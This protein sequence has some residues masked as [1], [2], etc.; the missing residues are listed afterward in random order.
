MQIRALKQKLSKT[1]TREKRRSLSLKGREAFTISK[2][3]EEKLTELE[4]KIT[5]LDCS[6]VCTVST[7][8]RRIVS[9]P[10]P[11]PDLS[12]TDNVS[13]RLRRKSLDSA[14]SSEPMKVLLRLRSL[15]S[16]VA[17]LSKDNIICSHSP[18]CEHSSASSFLSN[19][20]MNIS[21]DSSVQ[22]NPVELKLFGCFQDETDYNIDQQKLSVLSE[23]KKMENLLRS[24]LLE[25]AKKRESLIS[26]GQWNNE[27]RVSLLAEKL[28]Y[29]SVLIGRL[30]D[31]VSGSSQTDI[32]DSERLMSELDDKLSGNKPNIETSLDYL[33][34]TLSRH[35]LEQS[36][37]HI[38][39]RK[40]KERRRAVETQEIKEL[41]RKKTLVDSKVNTFIDE[42]TD[43]IAT[44]F[45]A[46][47][48]GDDFDSV[49]EK[50]IKSTWTLAQEAVNQEL[51]QAELSQVMI[52][53][54][55]KYENIIE[56]EGK[57]RFSYI[58]KER[59]TLELWSTKAQ[60]LLR[61]QMESYIKMLHDK[62]QQNVCMLKSQ[63]TSRLKQNEDE[64]GKARLLLGRF[65]D[66]VAHKALLD[67]RLSLLSDDESSIDINSCCADGEFIYDENLFL[68]EVQKLY[69]K[70]CEE[71]Q[72]SEE[73]LDYKERLLSALDY[74]VK[75]VSVLRSCVLDLAK[76][77][78]S[79]DNIA[80][81]EF[82]ISCT[83]NNTD[84]IESA[85][86][87]CITIKEVIVKLQAFVTTLHDCQRCAYLQ[88]EIKR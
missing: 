57:S 41:M 19:S 20:D 14:T 77:I 6:N 84:W 48:I 64:E 51:I 42:V 12:P 45:A 49:C 23:I 56:E 79:T 35:I 54:C 60:N 43:H 28:A 53:C 78:K 74:L 16:R 82:E 13:A 55:S 30:H 3:I 37:E 25:I 65:V 27:T 17:K 9:L 67:A 39:P 10:T 58:I 44:V 26:S 7:K 47:T 46:E 81:S 85:C 1:E 11:S 75:E 2:E 80:C 21:T 88:E 31:A 68:C 32:I 72:H 50:R 69:I 38:K 24:K 63:K 29:E 5:R 61:R 73:R 87:K 59:A 70:Y 86:E 8:D 15:D 66:I 18:S 4:N 34:R 52:Q 22:K 83:K 36:D 62:Y 76:K 40:I 33:T 71:L